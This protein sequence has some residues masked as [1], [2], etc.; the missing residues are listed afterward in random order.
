MEPRLEQR[1]LLSI[2]RNISLSSAPVRNPGQALFF[3]EECH[4]YLPLEIH[5]GMKEDYWMEKWVIDDVFV[6][7]KALSLKR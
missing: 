3:K 7:S 6:S 1:R 4:P 2:N 5:Q